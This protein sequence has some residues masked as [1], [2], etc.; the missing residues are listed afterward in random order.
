[1]IITLLTDFGTQD[2]YVGAMKGV[3]ATLCPTARTIDLT[4]AIPPQDVAAARF[5]WL[6]AYP[7]FPEGTVHLAVVDPGVGTSRR[8][9]ALQSDHAWWVGPDN[10]L[11]SGFTDQMPVLAAVELTN[12]DYWRVP[13][14]SP[15]FHGR[16]IFAA[17]AA[18]LV[19]GVA[20]ERLGTAI[21]PDS[22]VSLDLPPTVTTA[23]GVQGVI[24]YIDRFGNAVTTI[25]ATAVG[26][27]P[28]QVTLA[29]LTIP[30]VGTYSDV[31]PGAPLALIGS[32]GY[33]EIAI[34]QGS[35]Q[36]Q[37]QIAVGMAVVLLG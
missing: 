2:T 11:F 12:P 17:A 20:L 4:H 24:Q 5:N 7:Y 35:A 27:G 23:D 31:E 30:G 15:T 1:M 9:I 37:L 14:P 16:D 29:P 10:G 21:A 28:W 33:V 18:H 25:P 32:H 34:N 6:S 13:N 36:R 22:L 26:P 19:Q 3:I 8:G